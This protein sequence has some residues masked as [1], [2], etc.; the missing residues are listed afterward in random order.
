MALVAGVALWQ[1]PARLIRVAYQAQRL[2]AGLDKASV[3]IDGSRWVY[4]YSDDAPA[5][6]ATVVMLHGF[7][8]SKENWY[9]LAQRLRGRYRLLIPDLPGWGESREE[10]GDGSARENGADPGYRAQ[11]QRVARFIQT[12]APAG[13][14]ER[15]LLGHSMGGGIAAVTAAE[16]PDQV[17]RV[18][19][20]AAAGVY[21]QANVF[22]E[23]VLAGENPFAVGD[24]ASLEHYLGLLFED[25]D[26]RPWLPW[27]ADR[28]YIDQRRASAAFEQTV[29]DRIG[30]SDEAFLPGASAARIRQPALLLWC[31]QD[32]VIDASA[33]T[34]YAREM[35]Q[36]REVLLDGCGHMSLMERPDRVAAAV[37]TLIERGQP[38]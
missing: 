33:M 17:D 16:H 28:I 5:G 20:L 37:D 22:G 31:R 11:A 8:G 38:R 27:P 1:E 13:A 15:V 19:L 24:S 29:L 6:A 32:A 30:R 2:A 26:A 18:G 21:F 7:T 36:A 23:R 25:A 9:P 34:L 3:E 12:L 14:G 4:A 10:S 35:P